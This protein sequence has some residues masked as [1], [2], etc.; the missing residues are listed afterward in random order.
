[1]IQVFERPLPTGWVYPCTIDDLQN[2]IEYFPQEDLTGL[3]VIGLV[4][5]T[6]KDQLADARYFRGKRPSIYIYSIQDS[7]SFK[8]PPHVR[9][10]QLDESIA[11]QFGMEIKQS[12]RRWVCCWTKENLRRFVLDYVLPHEVGHHV[13]YKS[14]GYKKDGSQSEKFAHTYAIQKMRLQQLDY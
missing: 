12:G 7:L 13:F 14:F 9:R 10:S 6:R 2:R 3:S 1:M 5:S 11:V 4:P 8:Q